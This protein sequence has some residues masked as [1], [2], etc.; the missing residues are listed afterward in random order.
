MRN[1]IKSLISSR[2]F[3]LSITLIILL[4]AALVGI[5]L[6]TD[7]IVIKFIQ[8]FILGIFTLELIA[9]R[10]A[11]DNWKEFFEDRWNILDLFIILIS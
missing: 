6:S 7:N 8:L 1:H 10:I 11:V 5:E 3:E 2:V 9:R 4:N